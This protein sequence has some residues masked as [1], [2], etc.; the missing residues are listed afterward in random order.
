VEFLKQQAGLFKG[1]FFTGDLH[2]HKDLGG[3]KNGG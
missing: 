3:R 2:L 1:T